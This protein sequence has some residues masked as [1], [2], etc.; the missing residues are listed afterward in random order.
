MVWSMMGSMEPED[1]VV[2]FQCFVNNFS[3]FM[4]CSKLL[5]KFCYDELM[6]EAVVRFQKS[7]LL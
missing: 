2:G 1:V 4:S 5:W 3:A 7:D 6:K